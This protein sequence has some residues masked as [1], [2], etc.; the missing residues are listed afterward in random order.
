MIHFRFVLIYL[1]FYFMN[2]K[3]KQTKLNVFLQNTRIVEIQ[4]KWYTKAKKQEGHPMQ[5][6]S[7]NHVKR[8]K[9]IFEIV[10]YNIFNLPTEYYCHFF[11]CQLLSSFHGKVT[12][13]K[14]FYLVAMIA[15]NSFCR[16]TAKC[17]GGG[18]RIQGEEFSP[19]CRP[20]IVRP[21]FQN[22]LGKIRPDS[23]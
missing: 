10:S 15:I 13:S 11:F 21:C 12:S 6:L 4:K 3:H 8:F 20:R 19:K 23:S 16:L 9:V 7:I 5:G 17:Q 1:I 2:V 18:I 14:E 22:T